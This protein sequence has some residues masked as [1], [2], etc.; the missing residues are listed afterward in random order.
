MQPKIF[1]YNCDEIQSADD[2]LEH[3]RNL[4]CQLIKKEVQTNYNGKQYDSS[5]NHSC[6]VHLY[7]GACWLE[8]IGLQHQAKIFVF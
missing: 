1:F 3:N 7:I 5:K 2:H 4:T 8:L 6:H